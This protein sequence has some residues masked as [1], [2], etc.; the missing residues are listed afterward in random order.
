MESTL[1]DKSAAVPEEAHKEM[2]NFVDERGRPAVFL[3]L[4]ELI[5]MSHVLRL[6]HC[7]RDKRFSE[8]D[9]VVHTGGGDIHAAYLLVALLRLH[10]EK[11]TAC[12]PLIAKSA[13]TLLCIG[14]DKIV[15]DEVAQLGP[16]DTQIDENNVSGTQTGNSNFSSALNPF[17][18][19]EHLEKISLKS[20]TNTTHALSRTTGMSLYDSF[21]HALHFV[22]TTTGPLFSQLEPQ[23][24]GIYRRALSVGEEYGKRILKRFHG[25]EDEISKETIR[26]IIHD[27]PS[28]DYIIDLYELEEMGFD[29][30][31][32]PREQRDVVDG[33]FACLGSRESIVT[34]VEPTTPKN[35]QREETNGQNGSKDR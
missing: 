20:F 30:E 32:F 8:L 27:Y 2:Q 5:E 28:H 16:L 33:L 29:A 11:L 19:L 22:G 4:P 7:L 23:K 15:L 12:V 25:W 1:R 26:R 24:F 17:K 21:E 6:R 34:C 13:G 31:L 18:S 9:V 35:L 10:A 14:M 3:I